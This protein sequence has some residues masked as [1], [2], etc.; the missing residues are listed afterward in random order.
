MESVMR[1]MLTGIG[2]YELWGECAMDKHYMKGG[3]PGAYPSFEPI[4]KDI[5]HPNLVRAAPQSF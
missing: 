3:K 5:G 1:E 4:R 2:G